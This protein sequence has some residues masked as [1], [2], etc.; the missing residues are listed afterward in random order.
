MYSQNILY[1]IVSLLTLNYYKWLEFN[2]YP[3]IS[4]SIRELWSKRY[5]QLIRTILHETIFTPSIKYGASK[6][7]AA[8]LSFF[9][10][11]LIHVFVAWK[12]FGKGL[13]ST[14]CFFILHGLATI[15]ESFIYG[16][17]RS[18]KNKNKLSVIEIAMRM[19]ITFTFFV[20][21]LPLYI[22]LFIGAYP[23]WGINS[24]QDITP[25]DWFLDPR[26]IVNYLPKYQCFYP[27]N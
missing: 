19:Y 12:T 8:F 27:N 3:L 10:S 23:E 5:N 18:Y 2:N 13:L 4:I 21:T 22:G 7:F 14:I 26:N 16:K 25:S 9:V 1:A 11:G 6:S 15:I 17:K 20:L 24:T